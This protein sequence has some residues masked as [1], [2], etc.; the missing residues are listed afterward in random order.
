MNSNMLKKNLSENFD[1]E[2]NRKEKSQG[3]SQLDERSSPHILLL[4]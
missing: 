1:I 3:E 4:K 2:L